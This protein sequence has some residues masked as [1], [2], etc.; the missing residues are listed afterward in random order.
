MR[1]AGDPGPPDLDEAELRP[2]EP[3]HLEPRGENRLERFAQEVVRLE[4][5]EHAQGERGHHRVE[6]AVRESSACASPTRSSRSPPLRAARIRAMARSERV[7]LV[8]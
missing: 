4:A 2:L 1:T 8:I 5:D 3:Q 6:A 7:E